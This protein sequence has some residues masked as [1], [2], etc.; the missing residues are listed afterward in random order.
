MNAQLYLVP[1]LGLHRQ[2]LIIKKS[3]FIVSISRA[4]NPKEARDW[5]KTIQ[6]EFSSATHNCWAY[7]CGAA[8]SNTQIGLSDDGE[9]HGTAGRPILNT[10]LHA[11]LGEIALV[12]TRFF[13][14]VKLGT[15]G[16][17][18]AY[19]ELAKL[20]LNELETEYV[21]Y[22]KNY[23]ISFNYQ[24]IQSVKYLCLESNIMI[25]HENFDENI[26]FTIALDEKDKDF[27]HEKF[28]SITNG[29]GIFTPSL[30]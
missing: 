4:K 24:E 18:K 14:G 25:I 8:K 28:L 15:G 17:V 9:P 12:V 20:G 19:T 27:F 23:H 1:K 22:Y 10:L 30:S 21:S 16:L 26:S 13:G 29:K 2:S 11:E 6:E 7:Q 5:I 3:R